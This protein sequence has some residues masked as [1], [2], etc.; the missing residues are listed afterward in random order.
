MANVLPSYSARVWK[1]QL[2]SW[3]TVSCDPATRG[4][5]RTITDVIRLTNRFADY[6][7]AGFERVSAIRVDNAEAYLRGFIN[8]LL[9]VTIIAVLAAAPVYLA[10]YR[11][12]VITMDKRIKEVRQLLLIIPEKL[13]NT[14]PSVVN[15]FILLS[16]QTVRSIS[17]QQR[18]Q[19]QQEQALES[20]L[21]SSRNLNTV[22]EEAEGGS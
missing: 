12:L 7:S 14:V 11:P 10:I 13:I 1:T 21:S 2:T 19:K 22:A 9:T 3:R 18:A 15:A 6:L 4:D 16:G 20:I 8:A 17:S 5:L